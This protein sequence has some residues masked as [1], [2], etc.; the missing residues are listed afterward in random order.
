[1]HNRGKLLLRPTKPSHFRFLIFF[2][3]KRR[4]LAS[5]KQTFDADSHLEFPFHAKLS[6]T[7]AGLESRGEKKFLASNAVWKSEHQ[8]VEFDLDGCISS[9]AQHPLHM[10]ISSPSRLV[11]SRLPQPQIISA[12]IRENPLMRSINKRRE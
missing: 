6:A 4:N 1:M 7:S 12:I 5:R 3:S 2:F 10:I 9:S 8:Q 11:V